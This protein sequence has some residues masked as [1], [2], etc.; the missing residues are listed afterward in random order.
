MLLLADAAAEPALVLLL[1]P[2]ALRP[3]MLQEA[4]LVAPQGSEL[5]LLC[6][7]G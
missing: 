4:C 1:L 6:R 3:G 7:C 5:S 2:A